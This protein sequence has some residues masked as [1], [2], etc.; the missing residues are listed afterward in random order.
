MDLMI[1]ICLSK[2]L[3]VYLVPN[4][5]LIYYMLAKKIKQF[6]GDGDGVHKLIW[7]KKTGPRLAS[8][9]ASVEDP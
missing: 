6:L 5:P 9:A 1:Q 8:H 2:F 4:E 7:P 3:V